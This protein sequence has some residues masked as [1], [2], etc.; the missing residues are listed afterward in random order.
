MTL[1]DR[2]EFKMPASFVKYAEATEARPPAHNK[3]FDQGSKV[4]RIPADWSVAELLE[5]LELM[6]SAIATVE[7]ELA[8]AR[9]RSSDGQLSNRFEKLGQFVADLREAFPAGDA[10]DPSRE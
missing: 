1:F 10:Y 8:E 6:H 4:A 3:K 2:E 5:R 9:S 7:M